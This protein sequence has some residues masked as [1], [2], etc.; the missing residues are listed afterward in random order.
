MLIFEIAPE[1]IKI[2]EDILKSIPNAQVLSVDSFDGSDFI[3][4]IIP[5]VSVIMPIA[6]TV[7][8]KYFDDNRV[9]I[10][11]D[12]VEI[13]A[14]GYDKAMKILKE[15]IEQREANKND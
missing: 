15:V 2:K 4:V 12:G 3:Q 14:L 11:F 8:Q 5:L 6:S 10:K 7:I 1:D 13:S 9:T